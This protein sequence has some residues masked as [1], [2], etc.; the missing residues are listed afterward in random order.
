MAG[1]DKTYISD[2]DT[3][4]MI[5]NWAR[6]KKITLKNGNNVNLINYMYYPNLTKEQWDES[7]KEYHAS[8]P[9]WPFEVVLW[10]TPTYVDV[11]LIRNCPFDVIQERLK[12]QYGGGWS[13]TAFTK[14]N[15]SDLYEQI[16][17]GTSVYDTFERNGKGK[18]G[19][20][21]IRTIFGRPIRDKRVLYL[22][23]IAKEANGYDMWYDDDDDMWYDRREMMPYNTNTAAIRKPLTRKNIVNIVRRWDLPSGTVMRFS[24]HLGRYVYWEFDVTVK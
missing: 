24:A 19:K 21:R 6:Q 14:H 2:W 8:H 5:R 11:W 3:F 20:V 17:N 16:K 7:E 22:V 15:D 10:N 18:D 4:D 23:Q 1:I 9:D 12:E 13:K